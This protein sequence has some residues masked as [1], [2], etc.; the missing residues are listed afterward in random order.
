MMFP[1]L[2]GKNKA[3]F[4]T[5]DSRHPS[6]EETL[7]PHHPLDERDHQT[8]KTVLG[9]DLYEKLRHSR[10]QDGLCHADTILKMIEAANSKVGSI[11]SRLMNL[12][13]T[14][15]KTPLGII[16]GVIANGLNFGVPFYEGI[17]GNVNS[18][19]KSQLLEHG[20][21]K[22][23]IAVVISALQGAIDPNS[24]QALSAKTFFGIGEFGGSN[25]AF[26]VLHVDHE[27]GQVLCCDLD[28]YRQN[29]DGTDKDVYFKVDKETFR[30][31]VIP[32][33]NGVL[34]IKKQEEAE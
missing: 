32:R 10:H 16:G 31:Q 4:H 34:A 14:I 19:D 9:T 1:F 33:L 23:A 13:A 24:K 2:T 18:Y 29:A 12:C 27:N 21:P 15:Q 11:T 8:L 28:P 30:K 25:H 7:L 22:N 26:A 3:R 5:T 20:V 17:K 6:F